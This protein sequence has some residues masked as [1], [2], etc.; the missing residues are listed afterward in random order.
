MKFNKANNLRSFFCATV[1][2]EHLTIQRWSQSQA[3]ITIYGLCISMED[4]KLLEKAN[5]CMNRLQIGVIYYKLW[6]FV[7]GGVFELWL[8]DGLKGVDRLDSGGNYW[9]N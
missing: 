9:I 2:E 6:F 8:V 1:G 4:D 3:L 7:Y 5:L